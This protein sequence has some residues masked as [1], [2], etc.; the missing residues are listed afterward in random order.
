M[1][2]YAKKT[3]ESLI[4]SGAFDTLYDN[5]AELLMGMEDILAYAHRKQEE[6]RLTRNLAEQEEVGTSRTKT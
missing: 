4:Q 6:A 2:E 5:R 1:L 3:L